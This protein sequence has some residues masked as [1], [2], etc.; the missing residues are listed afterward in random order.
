MLL[1][2]V[3]LHL[4]LSFV[5][6][7]LVAAGTAK[8]AN[9]RDFQQAMTAY[10]PRRR[11]VMA[12]VFWVI[13]EIIAG[14]SLIVPWSLRPVPAVWLLSAGTGAVAKRVAQRKVHDCGCAGGRRK[15]TPKALVG[16]LTLLAFLILASLAVARPHVV[17]VSALGA[18]SSAAAGF[19]FVGHPRR[20]TVAAGH[21]ATFNSTTRHLMKSSS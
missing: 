15:T 12:A 4:A 20:K 2:M 3:V 17:L 9:L 14:L 13:A 7:L 10:D 6:V 18:A 21:T 19:T 11:P 16:N 8:L 5:G 1:L